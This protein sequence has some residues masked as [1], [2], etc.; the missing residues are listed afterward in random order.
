MGERSI[1][2]AGWG[3]GRRGVE[4][5]GSRVLRGLM[6]GVGDECVVA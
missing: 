3:N 5:D 2:G 1:C 4:G 6:D